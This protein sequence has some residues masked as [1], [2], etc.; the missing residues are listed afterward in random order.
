VSGIRVA[1]VDDHPVFALGMAGLLSSLDGIEVVGTASSAEQAATLADA[2][3]DVVLMDLHL[4]DDSG[5]DVTRSLVAA[6]PDIKVLVITMREDDDAV[7]ASVRAGARG[8][9]L[10]AAAPE[11]VE[12]AI[13]AV[14]NGEMILG[15]EVAERA[16][17]LLLSGRS[18]TRLPLPELTD[19]EREVLDLVARG[20]DNAVISRRLS[21]STKTVRNHVANILTKLAL[22]DRSAAIVRAREEGLGLD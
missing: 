17:G 7:I 13:R 14:A 19:R 20:L 4:G 11:E 2:K 8:Y 18:F 12:R 22:P 16:M 10:K 5:I 15:P 3:V 9:L 1:I 6:H 21:L